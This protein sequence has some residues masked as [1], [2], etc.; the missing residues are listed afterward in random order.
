MIGGVLPV[1]MES[2]IDRF[3]IELDELEER[4]RANPLPDWNRFELWRNRVGTYL[5]QYSSHIP[6]RIQTTDIFADLLEEMGRCRNYLVAFKEDLSMRSKSPSSE[7]A[8]SVSSALKV[9]GT[10]TDRRIAWLKD[11]P[12]VS[13]VFLLGIVV[14]AVGNFTEA[15]QSIA[16]FFS[17]K[18]NSQSLQQTVDQGS[19]GI[20]AGG[21]LTI[22]N[23]INT[24]SSTNVLSESLTVSRFPFD[25]QITRAKE[26]IGYL[27]EYLQTDTLSLRE[28]VGA[29]GDNILDSPQHYDW[30]HVFQ[31][32]VHQR[33]VEILKRDES[34]IEFRVLAKDSR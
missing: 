33:F 1:T 9:T 13:I 28:V 8:A 4:E 27:K 16:S 5:G 12:V 19:T 21:D 18:S 30:N 24:A 31:E 6:D 7:S 32:L 15:L 23:N 10:K 29:Y 25:T 2:E 26:R 20:Q 11:H 3:L 22:I 17:G 14:I 34:N